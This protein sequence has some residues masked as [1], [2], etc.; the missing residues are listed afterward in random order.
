MTV[1]SALA[2][3]VAMAMC[4][5]SSHLYDCDAQGTIVMLTNRLRKAT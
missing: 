3:L 1:R 5:A 4:R 2:L